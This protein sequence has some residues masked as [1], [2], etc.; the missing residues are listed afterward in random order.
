MKR[1]LLFGLLVGSLLT[2]SGCK[3]K[4]DRSVEQDMDRVRSEVSRQRVNF[5]EIPPPGWDYILCDETDIGGLVRLGAEGWELVTVS[6]RRFIL[7]RRL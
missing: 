6:N 2:W 3:P 1:F 7:K 5:K 4:L